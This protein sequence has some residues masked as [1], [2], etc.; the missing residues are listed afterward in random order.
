MSPPA[1][2]SCR[3]VAVVVWGVWATMTAAA[4]GYVWSFARD[5]PWWDDWDLVPVLSGHQPATAAW[6]WARHNEHLLPIP[7][8]VHL[9]L[10]A[11]GGADFRAGAYLNAAT[12]AGAALALLLAARR[13]RGHTEL[14][15]ALFPLVL[16]HWGQY[17]N[18]LWSFQVQFICST[19]LFL[20]AVVVMVTA[21]AH[22]LLWRGAAVGAC[23]VALPFCGVNGA[24]LVPALV[25][26]LAGAA[27]VS[28]RGQ[29]P[30]ARRD[31]CALVLLGVLGAGAMAVSLLGG[32]RAPLHPPAPDLG[33]GLLSG[34]LVL[35]MAAG[36]VGA[37]GGGPVVGL[38]LVLLAVGTAAVLARAVMIGRVDRLRGLGVLAALGGVLVLGAG[39]GWGRAGLHVDNPGSITG[40]TRYITLMAPLPCCA[41]LACVL[42]RNRLVP[43]MLLGAAAMMLP[44]NTRLGHEAARWRADVLDHL[45]ADAR[46]GVP[47]DQLSSTYRE[48]VHAVDESLLAK[49]LAMLREARLGPY[50]AAD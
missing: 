14:A 19:T 38:F 4:L 10:A 18:L 44:A 45:S 16:L 24:V 35:M 28:W 40:V 37:V 26:W 15:D 29:L 43:Y 13:L 36:P 46:R 42:L 23:A 3:L 30:A 27:V 20:I 50:T 6:L 34:L 39:V 31:A 41:A 1:Q 25:L 12:L 7:K 2:A 8:L 5:V 47:P 11:A 49:R 32:T 33:S 48:Y 17:E 22:H 21:R 9:A